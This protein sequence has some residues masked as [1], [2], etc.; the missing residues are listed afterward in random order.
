MFSTPTIAHNEVGQANVIFVEVNGK[1]PCKKFEDFICKQTMISVFEPGQSVPMN[2]QRAD[3]LGVEIFV[4]HPLEMSKIFSG[5][6]PMLVVPIPIK[7]E[8]V[9]VA[10]TSIEEFDI[11]FDV[12]GVTPEKDICVFFSNST[13]SFRVAPKYRPV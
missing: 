12:V 1:L 4:D 5:E 11:N 10:V 13:A 9:S 2:G 3:I 7:P 8:N 6:T